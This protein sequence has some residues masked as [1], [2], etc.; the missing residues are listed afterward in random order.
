MTI[1][2]E[3]SSPGWYPDPSGRHE[4]RFF[5]GQWTQHVCTRG[6]T[7]IDPLADSPAAPVGTVVS[8]A[9]DPARPSTP[10]P[11]PDGPNGGRM[12]NLSPRSK[13]AIGA[14]VIAVAVG[15]T[16][17]ITLTGGSD[18]HSFCADVA[19]LGQEN[20]SQL[21]A[22]DLK[23]VSKLSRIAGQFDAMAAETSS[24]GNATD[25]RYVASWLRKLA[26]GD[27]ASAQAGQAQLAAAGDRVNSYI[28]DTCPG[29]DVNGS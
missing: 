5:D 19:T 27:Y 3:N 13:L 12:R 15:T 23:N 21:S 1:D 28:E 24:P 14:G 16:L 29:L 7:S 25:L 18:G 9:P 22:A 10:G 20:P 4:L 2:E 17:A 26:H 6:T 8:P 11:M